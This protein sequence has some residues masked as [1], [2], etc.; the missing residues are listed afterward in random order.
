MGVKNENHRPEF[1]YFLK[2]TKIL[3]FGSKYLFITP[4]EILKKIDDDFEEI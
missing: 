4:N 3:K 2:K 1:S